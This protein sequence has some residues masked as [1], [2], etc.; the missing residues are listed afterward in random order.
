MFRNV[1]RS[2]AIPYKDPFQSFARHALGVGRVSMLEQMQQAMGAVGKGQL[3]LLQ[4]MQ[5]MQRTL[6]A[7]GRG[8]L[9]AVRQMAGTLSAI[10][11]GPLQ[12]QMEMFRRMAAPPSLRMG[13]GVEDLARLGA[14]ADS[15]GAM[16][17]ALGAFSSF[18][19]L[20]PSSKSAFAA[21]AAGVAGS[22]SARSAAAHI[23]RGTIDETP[24][25]QALARVEEVAEDSETSLATLFEGLVRSSGWA[26]LPENVRELVQTLAFWQ[27]LWT[28]LSSFVQWYGAQGQ[29]EAVAEQTALLEKQAALLQ[30]IHGEMEAEA[31]KFGPE[32]RAIRRNCPIYSARSGKSEVRTVLEKGD[33]VVVLEVRK[34]WILVAFADLV[35]GNPM[36]G[37]AR[38]KCTKAYRGRRRGL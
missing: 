36:L 33:Q 12:G 38:K 17:S 34:K 21:V 1:E 26:L 29:A 10:G 25:G 18:S 24:L 8:P 4:Q 11:A 14:M 9:D 15:V 5:Q 7:V 6:D 23:A 22:A 20:S 27:F 13:R 3:G 37:W 30:K 16:R 35:T 19:D 2:L 28:L 32:Y 31:K